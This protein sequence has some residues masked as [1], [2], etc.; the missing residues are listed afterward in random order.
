ARTEPTPHHRLTASVAGWPLA[1]GAAMTGWSLVLFSM[2]WSRYENFQFARYDLGNMVQAVRSTAE[3]RPLEATDMAGE[4][5]VRLAGHVDP[6][7]VLLAPV[8]IVAPSPLSL[9]AVQ[10]AAC[11][12]GAL[13]VFWL[14]RKHLDSEAAGAMLALAYLAYPWLA[15]TVLDAIHPVTLAIPLLLYAVWFL[16]SG[17]PW[18]FAVCALLV[19]TTGELMGLAIG[20]LGLWFWLARKQRWAGLAIA[21]AG[22]GWT[23]FALKVVIPH[24]RGAKSPF[25]ANYEAVGGSPEGIIQMAFTEPTAVLSALTSL[26]D[27]AYLFSLSAPLAGAFFLAPGI[28]VAAVPQLAANMLSARD[29]YVDP[30]AHYIAAIVPFV[31]A[32]TIFGLRRVRPRSR[33]RVAALLLVLSAACTLLLGPGPGSF[34]KSGR[35]SGSHSESHIEALREALALV[36]DG[37]PV[38]ATN[39]AGARLSA[40]RY[41]YNVPVVGKAEWI[42]VDQ[43]DPAI[44][45]LGYSLRSQVRLQRFVNKIETAA[46]WRKVF[47]RERVLVFRRADA[48]GSGPS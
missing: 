20:G 10:I 26:D 35:F 25:Y 12:L 1:I 3:G 14:G 9:A 30:R 34:A 44:P 48:G 13:P 47:G 17:R 40:R 28:V 43:S 15:W 39:I 42:V 33:V 6:I 21:A 45:A 37:V 19:L 41:Y 24:Y 46:G 27:L 8:W 32:A 16:D 11:S 5:T 4:Q 29:F 23:V 36:P 2:A 18:A 7:L 38:S 31:F 22:T